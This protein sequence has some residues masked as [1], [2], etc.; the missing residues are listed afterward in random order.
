[1]LFIIF[2]GEFRTGFICRQILRERG[3]GTIFKYNYLPEE[4]P[5]GRD[6]YENPGGVY[7]DWFD[8]K[9]FATR[10]E[11]ERCDYRYGLG[12]G[13]LIL[14]FDQKQILDAIHGVSDAVLTIGA[15][16]ID[17][18][19]QIK[20]AFGGYVT[21][22]YLFI[23]DKEYADLVAAHPGITPGEIAARTASNE[24]FKQIYLEKQSLFDGV[25][26]CTGEGT[27][28]DEAGLVRQLDA[29]IAQRKHLELSL[30]NQRYVDLPYIGGEP[31]IFI[32]YSHADKE[33]VFPFLAM[34]QRNGFRVWYDEGITGG[35]NWRGTLKNK[36]RE[37]A[38]VLLFSSENASGSKAVL[39]EV[40]TAQNFDVR[41]FI[42]QLD[43]S[44]YDG[45]DRDVLSQIQHV[46]SA[47]ADAEK[48]LVACL[49]ESTRI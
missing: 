28:F 8:D 2:G 45:I 15:S 32:S 42:L 21:L 40:T 13:S 25:L 7:L 26:F 18:V 9:I 29:Y 34:L 41:I 10:E 3:F 33:R 6:K 14:G 35:E 17:F 12:D 19:E 1:M 48:K 4:S 20:K 11:I 39:K 22:L 16:S 31:Y 5:L 43:E 23:S 47:S 30:N 27:A 46:S 38:C 49:P 36:I 24:K 44:G 37:A